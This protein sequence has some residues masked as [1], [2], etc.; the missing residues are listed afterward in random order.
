MSRHDAPGHRLW[1]ALGLPLALM[2]SLALTAAGSDA[3]AQGAAP[4]QQPGAK[5]VPAARSPAKKGEKPGEGQ[6]AATKPDP[7]AAQRAIESG[8][9]SYNAGKTDL[10][11]QQLSSALS[12]GKL[13]AQQMAR[14]LYYRGASYRKQSKPAQAIA[15]LTSALWLKNGLTD[16]E[17]ADA[18]TQ[19]SAAYREAGLP[20][21]ADA[22][23]SRQAQAK[24]AAIAPVAAA[25]V[26]APAP[27]PPVAAAKPAAPTPPPAPARVVE[28]PKPV[29]P[30]PVPQQVAAA[31]PPAPASTPSSGGVG[32]FFSNLFGG[33]P[34]QPP[35]K[36]TP[37]PP[38]PPAAQTSGWT[39]Q[40]QVAPSATQT[41]TVP[42][43]AAAQAAVPRPASGPVTVTAAT[44]TPLP[45]TPPAA[46]PAA[47]R[48]VET[49]AVPRTGDPYAL[50][51]RPATSRYQL[52]VAA[53]RTRAEAQAIAARIKQQHG[54]ET[55][56]REAVIDETTVGSMGTFYR[57]R[58]G[59]YADASEPREL[60]S[61]LRVTGVD[62]ML[63]T[64]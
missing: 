19:R 62:C 5:A 31:A 27:V 37:T 22:G 53:V 46:A 50:H 4:Q 21:Q 45:P 10:A 43:A 11:V 59:P 42:V 7:A 56:I 58:L 33:S 15:D 64:P 12:G 20:D 26:P 8:I 25:P 30:A 16:S 48:P 29:V 6:E 18:T 51:S 61:K 55:G 40:V 38:A 23:A 32:G 2:L 47:E 60:C 36:A 57:V 13:P 28:A 24:P 34:T 54:K 35:Q 52:Q 1:A 49:A 41:R 44:Q 39:N 14:A 3:H 63:V 9:A 17:R